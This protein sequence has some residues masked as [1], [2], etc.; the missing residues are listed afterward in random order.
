MKDL[1][2][3]ERACDLHV[4]NDI[5]MY[6]CGRRIN[7]A[8]H[9]Y[10]PQIRN[11]YLFVLVN[12]GRA[13]LKSHGDRLFKERD[14]LVMCPGTRIHYE[15]LT[16]WSISWVGLYGKTVEA[17]MTLLG[18]GADT[19]ILPLKEYLEVRD[20]FNEIYHL[21]EHPSYENDLL[22]TGRLYQFFNLLFINQNISY[23]TN[24]IDTAIK[25]MDYNYDGELSIQKIAK[26]LGFDPAYFSRL[27]KK[28]TGITPQKYI[29][30]KRMQRAE[31][32][33]LHSKAA[34]CEVA[35]SVGYE[36]AL[37]FSRIFKKSHGLSP[38][39]YRDAV[40]KSH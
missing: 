6:Y 18:I 35:C 4:Q 9:R 2:L 39:A 28:Q 34:V 15:A 38:S 23:S 27:F 11:H 14:L 10:G 32:L 33:L 17:M 8:H 7:T 37:Y 29:Q 3:S 24:P 1:T 12:S 26:D 31:Q 5:G 30:Q 22:I 19:P 40:Q 21:S 25:I 16:D 20:L 13:L 36:D